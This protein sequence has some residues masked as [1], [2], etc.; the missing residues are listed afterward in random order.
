MLSSKEFKLIRYLKALFYMYFKSHK[1]DQKDGI[2]KNHFLEYAD[3]YDK[4]RENLLFGRKEF[5]SGMELKSGGI[6]I[7]FGGGTG[8]TLELLGN[9]INKLEKVYIVD[10]SEELLTVAKARGERL[11]WKNVEYK[12]INLFD[13]KLP[14]GK[15]AD[16]ISFSYSLS[17]IP[18]WNN[19][20]DYS[21]NLLNTNGEFLL[22]DFYLYSRKLKDLRFQKQSSLK[23][24]ILKKYFSMGDV[25]LD[26][27]VLPTLLG[28]LKTLKS[29][30]QSKRPI[31]AL[32]KSP[33]FFYRGV[34]V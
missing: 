10:L 12:C 29:G 27:N 1:A 6:W 32:I 24:V 3:V 9:K 22:I 17:M 31:F 11:G 28:K 34:K 13:F 7:E 26:E 30:T 25:V 14:E 23:K 20:L 8:Y 21:L 5:Y 19:A 16:Y 2:I 18:H 4:L 33:Y 15:K